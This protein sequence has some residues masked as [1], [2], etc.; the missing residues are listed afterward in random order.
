MVFKKFVQKKFVRIFIRGE[1]TWAIAIKTVLREPKFRTE[2]PDFSREKTTRIQKKEGFMR[3][4]PN[5][6]GPSSSLPNFGSL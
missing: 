6:Y 4:P 5:R 1:R 3:T 2:F